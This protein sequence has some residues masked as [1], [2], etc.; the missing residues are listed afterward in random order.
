MLEVKNIS[1]KTGE[2]SLKAVSFTV[3]KGDYFILLGESG[4]GK[5][6]LLETIAGL[7]Q[8]DS[9]SVVLEGNDITHQKIQNRR[10]GLVFQD[11]AIFP[12]MTV[13]ENIAYSLHG[14]HQII[15]RK[16]AKSIGLLKILELQDFWAGDL[17]HFQEESFSGSHLPGLLFNSLLYCY[18]TSRLPPLTA[19]LNPS[20]VAS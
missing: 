11:H 2:F 10:I 5:S 19:E 20:S 7:V 12:H 6:M 8:P 1:Y 3:N 14:K 18:L 17:Q 15:K 16:E 9:G 13:F 4:A